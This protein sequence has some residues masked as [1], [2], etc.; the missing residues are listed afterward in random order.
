[1]LLTGRKKTT[2]INRL[3][4]NVCENITSGDGGKLNNGLVEYYGMLFNWKRILSFWQYSQYDHFV[5]ITICQF[6]CR[7]Y[8]YKAK[9]YT[10]ISK[11]RAE[12]IYHRCQSKTRVVN[13]PNLLPSLEGVGFLYHYDRWTIHLISFDL[14]SIPRLPWEESLDG[15]VNAYWDLI[16]TLRWFHN[17]L[18]GVSDHQPHDCLLNSLFG[19]R[20]KKTSKL[21]VTGLCPGNSPGTGEFPAQMASNAENVSIWWRHHD[22]YHSV[23]LDIENMI[24]IITRTIVERFHN[25]MSSVDANTNSDWRIP[26]FI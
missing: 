2:P 1:M 15:R 12:Y 11:M 7:L 22:H 19:R 4:T 14:S 21:R 3:T 8:S 6:E 17:E 16:I 5:K 9:S 10:C 20:L 13:C 26:L 24:F 18:D 25:Y 23:A